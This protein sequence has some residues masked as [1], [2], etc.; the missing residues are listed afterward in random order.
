MALLQ[1]DRQ[2]VSH[3]STYNSRAIVGLRE[4]GSVGHPL[5]GGEGSTVA[6]S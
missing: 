2:A 1:V 5:L 6:V 4:A 3:C